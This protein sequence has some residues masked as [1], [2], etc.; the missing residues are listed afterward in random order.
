MPLRQVY[1]I[2]P[3]TGRSCHRYVDLGPGAAKPH[4]GHGVVRT[5]VAGKVGQMVTGPAV[6]SR[7]ATN[8]SEGS[9]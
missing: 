4:H 9:R 7:K 1:T 8:N 5:L 2:D 3:E 6:S